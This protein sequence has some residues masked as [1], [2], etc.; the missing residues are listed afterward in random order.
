MRQEIGHEIFVYGGTLIIARMSANKWIET[1][2]YVARNGFLFLLLFV[3]KYVTKSKTFV[4][5]ATDVWKSIIITV[6][7]S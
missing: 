4:S 6:F 3:A 7:P 1:L 2:L 5:P